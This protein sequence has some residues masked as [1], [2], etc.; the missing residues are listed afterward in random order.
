[1]MQSGIDIL[2]TLKQPGMEALSG[3]FQTRNFTRKSQIFLPQHSEDIIFIVGKGRARLYLAYEDKEFTLAI[4]ERGDVYSTHT[5]A[6]VSALDDTQLLCAETSQV[7]RHM[8]SLPQ[9]TGAMVR[10]LGEVLKHSIS[11]IDDL[12]FRDVQTRLVR[13]LRFV[14]SQSGETQPGGGVLLNLGLTTEQ[15]ASLLGT[16]RQ[17][18]ST[19]LN[20]LEREGRVELRKRGS[21]FIPSLDLLG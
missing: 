1:M 11:I 13:F 3:C 20:I 6:F 18:L 19:M 4:L 5:R 7:R 14:A 10:V 16:T 9:F 21:I 17:T 8:L 15:F 2:T 12:A